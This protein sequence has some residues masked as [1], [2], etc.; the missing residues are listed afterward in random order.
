[1]CPSTPPKKRRATA[2]PAA[3]PN[4]GGLPSKEALLDYIRAQGGKVGKRDIARAFNLKGADR[5]ELKR[6][7]QELRDDGEI[8]SGRRRFA[9]PRA[10]GEPPPVMLLDVGEVDPDG[11]L[12][13]R[14]VEWRS[15]APVPRIVVAPPRRRD[16]ALAPGDRFLGRLSKLDGGEYDFAASIIKKLRRGGRRLLGLF[17]AGASGGRIVPV[18]KGDGE[19]LMVEAGDAADAR[20]GDLVEVEALGGG[21][22]GLKRA[23]VIARLGD[24][25]APRSLSLIA[26]H[27]HGVPVGFPDEAIQEADKADVLADFSDREDLR[28]LPFVTIDPPDARDH[29]DAVFA[30]ADDDPA[31]PGGWIVWVAI[32]DVA[33]YVRPGSALDQAARERGNST[34]FPDRVAPMLPERLSGELCSLH[35]DVDRPCLAVRM[36]LDADGAKLGHR[37][38]RSVIRSRAS[39]TYETAQRIW[40]ADAE[41]A[42]AL[43]PVVAPLFGAYHALR[44]AREKRCPLDLDL[45]ERQVILDDAGEVQAIR[46]RDRF[47]AHR[48]IEEFMIQAN[49]CAAE[50]L[51]ARRAPQL[52]RVHEPP[53]PKKL[54]A[55]REVL[56]SVELPLAKGQTVTPRLLNRVLEQVAGG[57]NA[58]LVNMAVLRSQ[59]QAYYSPEN[60]GHYGL[61]LRRY[62]HFTSPI[63]RYADLIVHRSLVS[64]LDLGESAARDGLGA[65][66][67]EALAAVAQHISMT[68]RRSMSAERDT[69][70]RYLAAYLAER[71]GA[72]FE[73]RIA[74]VQRFGLFVR[75]DETGADGLVPIGTIGQD[76]FRFDEAGARLIG[77]RSGVELRLGQPVAVRLVEATPISGGLIFELLDLPSLGLGSVRGG[78][79]AKSPRRGGARP[80]GKTYGGKSLS[81][82]RK[83]RRGEAR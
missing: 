25:S 65:V 82:T 63:R 60:F 41:A 52:Y 1:M 45:P 73:G 32:A 7:L 46:F 49:V 64:A 22:F 30:A 39:L 8:E 40:E 42:Q 81:R 51:E 83:R 33:Y 75:L 36:Q 24:P 57:D 18:G 13:A 6:R 4:G 10:K 34:Y 27:E 53:D 56:A 67:H 58:E 44:Q 48:L 2:A 38:C 70:D 28:D 68:E 61:S 50:T 12:T 21:R 79:G 5:V 14:P 9:T 54:E 17:R 71:R 31:N 35:E 43:E 66:E 80:K 15:S 55:L 29:D 16:P 3:T 77:E 20:D 11:E 76:Y 69:V 26:M 47:D 59:M 23:R 37:F 74:G 72:Q 62:A 78:R 19:E